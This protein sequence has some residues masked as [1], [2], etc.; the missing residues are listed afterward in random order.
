MR[1]VRTVRVVWLV[2]GLGCL[3][4]LPA[5]ARLAGSGWSVQRTPNR[6]HP[7]NSRLNAVSCVSATWCT[8]VGASDNFSE[9]V[10]L[11]ERWNGRKWKVQRVP[12]PVGAKKSGLIAVSCASARACVAV[13][14][15]VGNAL[16][17][18]WNGRKWTIQRTPKP[19]RLSDSQLLGVSCVSAGACIAV[20]NVDVGDQTVPLA[21]RWNG[22]TWRLMRARDPYGAVSAVLRG[23]SCTSQRA[24]T[25]V[26][27]SD[28][29]GTLVERWDGKQ[30]T[31]Q[32]SPNAP[33]GHAYYSRYSELDGV[34]CASARSCIAVG[35][36]VQ[37]RGEAPLSERWNGHKWTLEAPVNRGG[38]TTLMGVSCTGPRACT[39]VGNNGTPV[40]ER[41]NGT[42]WERQS[43]RDPMGDGSFGGVSCISKNRCISAGDYRDYRREPDVDRTLVERWTSG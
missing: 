27:S 11:A 24:C 41:W 5:A 21:E 8:A 18:R 14:G 25:A 12:N 19:T 17:E 22:R 30:W 26:G 42:K 9:Y 40:A 3:F 34:S 31:I 33:T 37:G 7:P 28:A 23:V 38:G 35:D 43:A 20:G 29:F 16:V 1:A 10:V 15:S 4:A 39:A 36:W 2:L 6:K 13:G 32:P